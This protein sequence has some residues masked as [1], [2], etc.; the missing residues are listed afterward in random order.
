MIIKEKVVETMNAQI[1]S[2]FPASAQCIATAIYF[3][4][5]A[6]P[7]LATVFPQT[8]HSRYRRIR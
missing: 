1:E 7:E 6:L 4:E 2:E 5:E 8:F 3:Y